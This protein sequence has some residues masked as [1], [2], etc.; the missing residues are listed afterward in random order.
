MGPSNQPLEVQIRTHQ[1]HE[2]AENGV[3]AHWSYKEGKTGNVAENQFS[4]LRKQLFDW[5]S[6]HR[7]SSDF[8]RSVSTDLFSEQVFAFTPKGDV[9]DLPTG[10]TPIDFAF[11]I[12]SDIG[13]KLVGAKINGSMVPLSAEIKNGDVV[14]LVTRSNAQPTIGWL[15]FVK[16]PHT[17]NKLRSY[18]RKRNKEERVAQGREA[19]DKEIKGMG[20][21][22]RVYLGDEMM[23]EV[24]K[25]L[26][27]CDTPQD[28]FARIGEGL[29]SV[30]SVTDR[31]RHLLP[32]APLDPTGKPKPKPEQPTLI[33]TGVDNVMVKRARCCQ[34]VP[35]EEVVGYVTRGR[36]VVLH[37]RVC[38][39]VLQLMDKE[40][41]RIQAV[42]W[43]AD[44]K[45]YEVTLKV[46]S[47]N[48]QGLL[49]DMSNCFSEA[50]ANV[51]AGT[52]NTTKHN[53]ADN[54][55]T[56]EVR[57][58]HHLRDVMARLGR[59]GDIMHVLRVQPRGGR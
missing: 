11:R 35:G 4:T 12:H 22:P 44:G 48:R 47:T 42:R 33:T 38:Q 6:D 55:F 1:M 24:I 31:I 19:L 2:I 58:I 32:E 39:N 41:D 49:A 56:I 57:D 3:A 45:T 23:K 46:L 40:A 37:Q 16:S 14:E 52:I 43:D 9:I 30:R 15:K 36:G 13:H 17:K 53:T 25:K 51:V 54:D 34:P 8:L 7:E 50:K 5:S 21:D 26:K 18:F 10:S 59:F 27:D 28:V 20:L 29:L